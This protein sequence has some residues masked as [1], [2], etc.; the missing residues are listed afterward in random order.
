MQATNEQIERVRELLFV[1]DNWEESHA[2]ALAAV[3]AELAALRKENEPLRKLADA[4][5]AY[6]VADRDGTTA[7][8]LAAFEVMS[9]ALAEAR[10]P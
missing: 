9:A 4:V 10:K 8:W 6:I 1:G 7:E 5:E 2:E 3:L